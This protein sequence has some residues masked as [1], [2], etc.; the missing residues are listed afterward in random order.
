MALVSQAGT[1]GAGGS[2][3]RVVALVV[4]GADSAGIMRSKPTSFT[5]FWKLGPGHL[6]RKYLESMSVDLGSG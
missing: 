3:Y 6:G 5:I 4:L 2:R 1:G